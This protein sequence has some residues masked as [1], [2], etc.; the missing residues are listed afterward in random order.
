MSCGHKN[1]SVK[2]SRAPDHVNSQGR[3]A[4]R[5]KPFEW[6]VRRVRQCDDCGR[7]FVTYEI[8]ESQLDELVMSSNRELFAKELLKQI[9]EVVKENVATAHEGK[10][11][12]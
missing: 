3:K 10:G 6:I 5:E 7:R 8:A 1:T 2:C 4:F 9:T 12:V 11:G